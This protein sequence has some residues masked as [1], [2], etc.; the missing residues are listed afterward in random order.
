M[1][2]PVLVQAHRVAKGLPADLALEGSRPAVRAAHVDLQAVRRGEHLWDRGETQ[3][4]I[5]K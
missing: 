3:V 4:D 1:D 5:K 2:G